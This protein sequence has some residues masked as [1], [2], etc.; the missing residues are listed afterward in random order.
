MAHVGMR[1]VQLIAD[2]ML[3]H[4]LSCCLMPMVYNG[5]PRYTSQ[6]VAFWQASYI[7]GIV[8][9]RAPPIS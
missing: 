7:L 1:F 9:S 8:Q 5:N 4:L 3:P 2:L 6:P